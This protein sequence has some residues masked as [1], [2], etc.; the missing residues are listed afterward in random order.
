VN[1]VV[2]LTVN[3]ATDIITVNRIVDVSKIFSVISL[4]MYSDVAFVELAFERRVV[5]YGSH[6]A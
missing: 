2:L 1:V 4:E 3:P 6:E 5:N